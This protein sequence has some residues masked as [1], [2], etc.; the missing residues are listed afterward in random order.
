MSRIK[1]LPFYERPREKAQRHGINKLSDTELLAVIIGSGTKGFSALE[2]AQQIIGDNNGLHEVSTI[3]L[4]EY[5]KYKGVS[6]II[7]TK[8]AA[9]FELAKRVN[10]ANIYNAENSKEVQEFLV[11]KYKIEIANLE[12]EVLIIVFLNKKKRVI[13]EKK[14]YM[15]TKNGSPISTREVVKELLISNA[16][17]FYLIHNHPN[18]TPFPS[19]DDIKATVEIIKKTREIEIEMIDHLIISKEFCY[20]FKETRCI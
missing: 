19:D 2:I 1:D 17:F 18:G 15:G 6:S 14:L 12:Q 13:K 11:E 7:S 20:S 3:D 4:E 16:S 9:V 8:I 10:L 5:Q